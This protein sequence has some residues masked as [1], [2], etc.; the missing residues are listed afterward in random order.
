MP[1]SHNVRS[2]EEKFM[3]PSPYDE[4]LNFTCTSQKHR[5]FLISGN[6]FGIATVTSWNIMVQQSYE[7]FN[8]SAT[9]HFVLQILTT[10]HL[11][12]VKNEYLQDSSGT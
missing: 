8:I 2:A 7:K 10:M 3:T 4:V 1:W 5:Q 9:V 12:M 11:G 6:H